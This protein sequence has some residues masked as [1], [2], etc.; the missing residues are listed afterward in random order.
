MFYR[1]RIEDLEKRIKELGNEVKEIG[2]NN[3]ER[4]VALLE[5][6]GAESI[7]NMKFKIT[8]KEKK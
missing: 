6:L 7:Y 1:E 4:Y 2:N 5:F 8:K 3:Y